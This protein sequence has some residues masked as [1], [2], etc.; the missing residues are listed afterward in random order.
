[1]NAPYH[2]KALP[3]G[4]LLREWKLEEVL[5][6]GGFGIVYRGRGIYFGELVAIKEYFPGAISDRK[7]GTTVA[8]TDSS[9]EEIYEL[10]RQKFLDEARVLWNLSQPQRHPNIVSVRSLFEI[11]GTAYMVMDFEHGVSLSQMLREGRGFDQQSLM[12]LI[13]PIAEGLTRV[14][15]EGVVHRDIK[16]A[17]I[18]IDDNGRPVLFD[19]GSARF[20]AGHATSTNVTFYTPPYAALEQYVRTLPQGPWT[21]IYGLGVTL[22]QCVAGEKPPDVLERLHGSAGEALA[23]RDWP[24]YSRAFTHAIDAAMAIRPADRPQSIPEWMALFDMGREEFPLPVDDEVTQIAR[25]TVFYPVGPSAGAPLVADEGPAKQAPADDGPF[26]G[27]TEFQLAAE[28]A[29]FAHIAGEALRTAQRVIAL[30]VVEKPWLFASRNRK[31]TY[32][33]LQD[34]AAAARTH[35]AE[36]DELSQTVQST[37]DVL[38][39][40]DALAQAGAIRQTLSILEAGSKTAS[41]QSAEITIPSRSTL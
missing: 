16:P 12:A 11:H 27:A 10:G 28:R 22:Y 15:E 26:T 19:F 29:Q 34:H 25:P 21:D 32:Q 33:Q 36:L 41:A 14:H 8:P 40:G 23:G 35:S 17:N 2:S 1:L 24:G 13:R 5:G 6:A 20:G 4:T 39:V 18:L 7:D 3:Q 9:A 31:D 38:A 30:G 37:T